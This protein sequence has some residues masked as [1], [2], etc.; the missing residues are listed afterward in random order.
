MNKLSL[1]LLEELA[2]TFAEPKTAVLEKSWKT[3][4][5]KKKEVS[6]H[7]SFPKKRK[8]DSRNV[9]Q[10][11]FMLVLSKIIELATKQVVWEQLSK[12]LWASGASMD[13]PAGG[14]AKPTQSPFSLGSRTDEAGDCCRPR[15][16]GFSGAFEKV[17]RDFPVDRMLARSRAG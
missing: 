14:Q 4:E 12:G 16:S 7:S 11:N 5:D 10:I 17:S 1:K 2:E 9:G 13:S 15:T 3:K 6:K 8:I